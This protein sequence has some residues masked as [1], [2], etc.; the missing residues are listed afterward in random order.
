MRR[1]RNNSDNSKF[2]WFL[3]IGIVIVVIVIGKFL[4]GDNSINVYKEYVKKYEEAVLKYAGEELE[5]NHQTTTYQY[6]DFTDLLVSKGYLEKWEDSNVI[7][8]AEPIILEK[9]DGNTYF[10]NYYNQETVENRFEVKFSKA[11]KVYVCTKNECK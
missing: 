5:Q 3:I 9:K 11:D 2:I 10:Y 6:S 7:L 8:E 1:R 4:I